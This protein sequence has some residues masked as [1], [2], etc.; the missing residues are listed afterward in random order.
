M[1]FLVDCM[2]T[3]ELPCGWLKRDSPGMAEGSA[4]YWSA[5]LGWAQWEHP[6]ISLLTG[7]ANDLKKR[8]RAE[9]EAVISAPANAVMGAQRM[10][11]RA[12]SKH[13]SKPF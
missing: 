7:V 12:Q 2:L 8:M 1:M 3:P 5:L 4:F 13:H 9:Q 11:S 10:T 6:Q